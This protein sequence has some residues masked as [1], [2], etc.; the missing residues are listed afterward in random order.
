MGDTMRNNIIIGVRC[1]SL[2]LLIL[3]LSL[4]SYAKI[5]EKIVIHCGLGEA[6]GE[7]Y[8]GLV[9]VF[10]AIRNRGHLNGVYGCQAKFDEPEWVWDLARKAWAS[11]ASSNLV[12][13]ADHWESTSFKVPYWAK[14]MIVTAHIGKHRFYNGGE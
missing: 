1:I 7:G 6:R 8:K 10:E 3:N 12:K 9:A 14:D 11:S 5:D 13:G 2:V 4:P